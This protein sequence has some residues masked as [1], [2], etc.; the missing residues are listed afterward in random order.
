MFKRLSIVCLI[1]TQLPFIAMAQDTWRGLV[2][3]EENRC[4]PYDKKK[5]Y[6]YSQS[7]EDDIVEDM[8]GLVYG[9]YTGRYFEAD[10]STDIEHIVAASEGHDSGLCDASAETRK[11]FAS[12]LLNL[13]LAAPE[14]NRCGPGGKCGYDAAEW[15][16]NKNKCWFANRIV[17]IKTK[18]SL[19]VD[20]AEANALEAVLSNCQSVAMIFYHE[21]NDLP[22]QDALALYDDNE[23]GHI[24]C[25][26]A[27]N[28]N[29]APVTRTHAA[30]QYMRDADGDGVVCE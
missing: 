21:N 10:T 22:R 9:P 26:E 28:H 13:T 2:V 3:T 25:T 8:D 6:P 19:S 30:Y 15:L 4:S 29:I 20:Q 24:S 17:E 16:P 14:I 11:E 1:S 12:D 23:N 18:Y 7:V 5:Q 27:R